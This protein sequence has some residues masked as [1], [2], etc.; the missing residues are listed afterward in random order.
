MF[1][2]ACE[3][4]ENPLLSGKIFA[5]GSTSMLSTAN[6]EARK[7]GIRAGMPGF[8][9]QAL[10]RK[11]AKKELTIVKSNFALYKAISSEVQTIFQEYDPHFSMMSLDEAYLDFTDHVASRPQMSEN[12]KSV[13]DELCNECSQAKIDIQSKKDNIQRLKETSL[14]RKSEKKLV[15]NDSKT[16]EFENL[17]SILEVPEQQPLDQNPQEDANYIATLESDLLHQQHEDEIKSLCINCKWSF[18]GDDIESAV[19]EM[20]LRVHR[21]TKLTCSA[22]IGPNSLISKICSDF[23]KPNG[24]HRIQNNTDDV[25]EFIRS[26]PVRKVPFV[27]KR[28]EAILSLGFGILTVDDLYAKRDL[29]P[30]GFKQASLQHFANIMLAHGCSI[31]RSSKDDDPKSMSAETTFV[32]TSSK[33]EIFNILE[34]LADGLSCDLKTR[35]LKGRTVT[36]K[37]KTSKFDIFTRSKTVCA[38]I[39]SRD[40]LIK[41]GM[42][43]FRKNFNELDSKI[44]LLGIQLSKF[45]DE[46]AQANTI[47]KFLKHKGTNLWIFVII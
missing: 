39:H 42:E 19:H 8:I 7:Y 44:R 13:L 25:I 32:A 24:Q 16:E 43:L 45:G 41:I 3:E 1:F 34:S 31:V 2:A 37:I 11:L 30:F 28:T 6:Y 47:D 46:Q 10:A 29:L 26:L 17:C 27:G 23:N 9:G 21:V 40:D 33:D 36:L 18:F 38:P 15:I 5:V 22:G 12:E 4:R 35:D 14:S 20:R